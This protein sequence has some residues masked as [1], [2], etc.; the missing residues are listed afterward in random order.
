MTRTL[1]AVA[2]AITSIHFR[3]YKAFRDFSVGLKRFNVLVGPNNAGKSTVLGALRILIEALK[4]PRVKK[5]DY[6]PVRN[7]HVRGYQIKLHGLPISTENVFHNYDDS[8]AA[9]VSFRLSNGNTLEL[10]FPT[11]EMCVLIPISERG[12]RSVTDFKRDFD[13]RISAVPVLGPLEHRERLFQKE[14]ARLALSTTTASR[15]VRNIWYHY[16]EGFDEFRRA[17]QRTWP[18]MD[19]LR[20][21]ILRDESGPILTMFCT[22]SRMDREIYWAGFGFQVWCQ[23]LTFLL[24]A[25]NSSLVIIDEPD[26]YLHADLQRRFVDFA[27][28]MTPSI[29]LATHSTEILSHVD[30]EHILYVDKTRKSAKRMKNP[31]QLQNVFTTLGSRLNPI[32]SQVARHRCAL[33]IEGNDMHLLYRFAKKL[34]LDQI[35]FLTGASTISVGGFNPQKAIALA[36]G[37]QA[38][39]GIKINKALLL[40]R[41]Y[42][43]EEEVAAVK[44]KLSESFE[45]TEI[46]DCKEIE[47][48]LL[49]PG[50]IARA[51]QQRLRE[52]GRRA[53]VTS[54][55]I[56]T[57][58]SEVTGSLRNEVFAQ[59]LAYKQRFMKLSGSKL[60][61]STITCRVLQD[62]EVT[63]EDFACRLAVVPGKE[64][65]TLLNEKL[66]VRFQVSL[67]HARILDE[68]R[69]SELSDNLVRILTAV[70]DLVRRS[71]GA[72]W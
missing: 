37:V 20:P 34:N 57:M 19:V 29:L 21:E 35:P 56:S 39:V 48:F 16:P 25:Q 41:D 31:A 11:R 36:E 49:V 54:D 65:L 62:F 45:V 66:Q 43:C 52:R 42:R 14:A 18:G 55:Q 61:E 28:K 3:N 51:V 13:V 38:A 10:V 17:I 70:N 68:L 26:I 71:L 59:I 4:T 8:E 64:V 67:S 40:D 46:L 33:F 22:E 60:D 63:W 44:H 72:A 24:Q 23:M 47:N 69:A 1:N 6:L 15:N 30:P 2:T 27:L 9:S 12:V 58:L 7:Q 53:E 32:L 5:P 50:A